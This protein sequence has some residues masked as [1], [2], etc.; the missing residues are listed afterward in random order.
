MA[1]WRGAINLAATITG[2]PQLPAIGQP[3]RLA[4]ISHAAAAPTAAPDVFAALVES[5]HHAAAFRGIDYL[6]AGLP[7]PD[8]RLVALKRLFGGRELRSRLYVVYW[9]DGRRAAESL[10]ERPPCPE[11][12]LL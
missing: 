5:L 10:D 7:A 4:Y 6:V 1:R 9:P 12:A 3:L 8:P 2:R 11:V